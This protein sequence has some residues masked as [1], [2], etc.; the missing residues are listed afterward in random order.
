[1][2]ARL[3]A[4]EAVYKA[5]QNLPGSAG[6]GWRDIE[7]SR[8]GSGRPAVRF[9]GRAARIFAATPGLTVQLSLTHSRS[10]AGAVAILQSA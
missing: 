9:H 1:M 7:V 3:A 4:K 2:A 5:F 10:A 6:I 8:D